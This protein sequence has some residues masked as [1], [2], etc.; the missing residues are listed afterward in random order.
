MPKEYI[1]LDFETTGV[2]PSFARIIEVGMVRVQNN[3]IVA[4]YKSLC[5]PGMHIPYFITELT[6]ISNSM[7]ADAPYPEDIMPEVKEFIADLPIVAHNASFDSKF[8][9]AEMARINHDIANDFLCTLLLA[10]RLIPNLTNYKLGTLKQ[11]IKFKAKKNHKAHRALDDVLVTQSLIEYLI[12]TIK[13]KAPTREI[14]VNLLAKIAK[15]P[16][17]KVENLICT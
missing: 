10:R 6:G 16:K 11:H 12:K 4:T 17:N 9:I 14:D 13:H 7:V 2:C 5:D 3:K 8:L 1:V 15:T